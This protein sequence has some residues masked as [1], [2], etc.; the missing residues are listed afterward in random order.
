MAELFNYKKGTKFFM[1]F[2][3]VPSKP[4]HQF[5]LFS[6]K[7]AKYQNRVLLKLICISTPGHHKFSK[8]CKL[9]RYQ[10]NQKS[11][12]SLILFTSFIFSSKFLDPS[13][14]KSKSSE[15]AQLFLIFSPLTYFRGG[16]HAR[17]E[18]NQIAENFDIVQNTLQ[19]L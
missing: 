8:N 19:R 17:T 12:C 18:S 16:L 10:K 7:L 4:L 14:Q 9:K 15:P 2:K 13:F 5:Y 1:S 6:K 11:Q 3:R